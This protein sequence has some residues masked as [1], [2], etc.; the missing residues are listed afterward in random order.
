MAP[1]GTVRVRGLGPTV[2]LM[3]AI[4]ATRAACQ[5]PATGSYTEPPPPDTSPLLTSPVWGRS[6]TVIDYVLM[7][8]HSRLAEQARELE[9]SDNSGLWSS[10]LP[11]TTTVTPRAFLDQ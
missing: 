2:S 5:R 6:L 4:G 10:T 7:E 11:L 3:V 9:N 1:G 8:L